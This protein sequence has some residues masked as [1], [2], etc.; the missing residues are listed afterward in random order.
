MAVKVGINGFGR[1]GRLVLRASFEYSDLEVVAINH[2]SRRLQAGANFAKT[3]AHTLKYDSVYGTLDAE[4]QGE[5]DVIRVDDKEVKVLA[6][7]DP[8][9]LPWGDL[10]VEIVV[11][12]TGRFRDV[13]SAS[14]HLKAGAKKVVVSAPVK[15]DCLMVVMGVNEKEYDPR[16]HDIVSNASCT[17]NCLAPVAKV[18]HEQFGI[19]KGLMTTV[20]A[21]TNDQQVLDMPHR[22]MRRGRAGF[23]SVIPTT[24]GAAK[25]VSVVLPE[26]EGKLN[27]M[28]MRV[29][30]PTVSVV[31]LVA[32]LGKQATAEDVNI[33]LRN[34]SQG[35]LKGIL[36]YSE[37]PLV[38]IDYTG[39]PHSSVIDA[40]S[41]MS[42]GDDLVKVL[43]WY[44]N[45]WGYSKR[46]VDL[47]SMIGQK[48]F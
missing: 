34:A 18:L 37:L 3:L 6:E 21:V 22:D 9:A 12:S 11:E 38:S 7:G 45:E 43:A 42:I 10:G 31:D 1:I 5:G 15:G 44:D 28:A 40:L 16:Q 47:V 46:I 23:M 36:G 35:V 2:K 20:H 26:L 24:T 13:D 14:M 27:G 33:A 39:N 41:T 17:T 30:T 32:Q 29:P 8:S 25:S 4:I 19:V 48:G